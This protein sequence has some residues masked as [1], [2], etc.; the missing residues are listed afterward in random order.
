MI[1]LFVIFLFIFI[2][3]LQAQDVH[4]S[5][6]SK[7]KSLLNPSLIS[8]QKNDYH[9]HLQRRS[10]W[11]SVTVPFNTLSFSFIVKNLYKD[12]SL[13]ATFLNDIAGDSYFSTNG[14]N[15]SLAKSFDSKDNFF[16]AAFFTAIYQRS[17]DLEGLIFLE[18]EEVSKNNFTFFDIGIGIS[19]YRKIDRNSSLL[20]GISLYHLN[21]PNQSFTVSEKASLHPKYIFHSTF[22][23]TINTKIKFAPTFYF[24]SQ[25]K[26]RELIIGSGVSYKLTDIIDLKS[27]LYTR[28]NDAI[29]V[30]FGLKK[31][32]FEVLISYDINTSSF[33]RASNS[34]GGFEFSVNYGWNVIKQHEEIKQKICPKYL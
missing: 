11:S 30:S 13:A 9:V 31:E 32:D 8:N 2:N 10:Q 5:Q 29:F 16:S 27:G 1:R 4:F 34:M 14:L 18:A 23:K 7:T 28:M 22:S 26:V 12:F 19:N 3:E 24:S 15:V 33:S 21:T 25:N 20:F 17:I 6:F